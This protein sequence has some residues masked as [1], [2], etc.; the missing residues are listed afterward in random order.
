MAGNEKKWVRLIEARKKMGFTQKELAEACGTSQTSYMRWENMQFQPNL[1]QLKTLAY[2]L[3]VTTDYLLS[4]D[5]FSLGDL[6][7]FFRRA[8]LKSYY[9]EYLAECPDDGSLMDRD[10]D[11]LFMAAKKMGLNV[12]D[13]SNI[14]KEGIQD[15]GTF[16]MTLVELEKKKR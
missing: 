7:W 5:E 6:D 14:G 13:I 9:R 10:G 15:D 3:Q 8:E 4:Y 2:L 16:P 12:G 11:A 1:N